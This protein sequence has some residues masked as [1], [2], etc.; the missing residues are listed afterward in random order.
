MSKREKIIC[1]IMVSVIGIWVIKTAMNGSNK[2][3][4]QNTVV[5]PVMNVD[6]ADEQNNTTEDVNH[7]ERV[8]KIIQ[9]KNSDNDYKDIKDPFQKREQRYSILDFS[10][11]SLSG[12]I[13]YKGQPAALINNYIVKEGESVSGFMV[14]QIKERKV[15]LIKGLERYVLSLPDS[16]ID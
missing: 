3:K 5:T 16:I 12:I 4:S 6:V 11:L 15:F 8:A 14:E 1:I 10:D 7:L 9:Y 2:N 13:Q